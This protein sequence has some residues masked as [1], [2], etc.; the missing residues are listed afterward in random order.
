VEQVAERVLGFALIALGVYL[1]GGSL[2]ALATQAHPAPSAASL[3]LLIASAA[4]LPTLAFATF[5]VAAHL[6][7]GA[8]RADSILTAVAATIAAISLGSLAAYQ[9]FGLW[10]ADAAAALIVAVVVTREVALSL[11]R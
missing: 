7:S 1:A 9:L 3:G 8:R 11:R 5:R 10:C 4:V 6:G 2:R